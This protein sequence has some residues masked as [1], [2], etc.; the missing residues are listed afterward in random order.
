MRV[1]TRFPA[2]KFVWSALAAIPEVGPL[3]GNESEAGSH[4]SL[5]ERLW[6]SLEVAYSIEEVMAAPSYG[7]YL[8][9]GG[10]QYRVGGESGDGSVSGL[11]GLPSDA[12]ALIVMALSRWAD[13]E[14]VALARELPL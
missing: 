3:A 10:A 8:E 11:A 13:R 4:H 7:G 12:A 1:V 2:R 5:Y 14:G 6:S 9:L